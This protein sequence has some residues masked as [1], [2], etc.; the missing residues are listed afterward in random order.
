[1][2]SAAGSARGVEVG[3]TKLLCSSSFLLT[4][5]RRS[6]TVTTPNTICFMKKLPSPLTASTENPNL[7]K[8]KKRKRKR[9]EKTPKPKC[10][11]AEAATRF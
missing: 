5:A 10:S 7:V 6:I 1:M 9:R 4:K 11:C 8:K 3:A 2:G